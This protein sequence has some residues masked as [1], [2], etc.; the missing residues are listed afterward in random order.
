MMP[1]FSNKHTNCFANSLLCA[2]GSIRW[3]P[4]PEL[5]ASV[6]HSYPPH[7]CAVI[8]C[9][10]VLFRLGVCGFS[11]KTSERSHLQHYLSCSDL[12]HG[13]LSSPPKPNTRFPNP[14][15]DLFNTLFPL[16]LS[17]LLV[18]SH[19]DTWWELF[20]KTTSKDCSNKPASLNRP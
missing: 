2:I 5:S 20:S 1:Q 9:H 18:P 3:T 11:C 6:L 19:L 12:L 15:R 16:S 17:L 14:C 13:R 4:R 8:Q 7:Y 10:I